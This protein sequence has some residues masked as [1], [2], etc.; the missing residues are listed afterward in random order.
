MRMTGDRYA[1]QGRTEK[2][3]HEQLGAS[4]SSG[5]AG[6]RSWAFLGSRFWA[7]VAGRF[8]AGSLFLA[9]LFL[10]VGSCALRFLDVTLIKSAR[11]KL[12]VLGALGAL[13]VFANCT[14]VF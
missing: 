7:F 14:E 5:R 8:V 12:A 13:G 3:F 9:F 1:T 10:A 2:A 4:A 6:P 11:R